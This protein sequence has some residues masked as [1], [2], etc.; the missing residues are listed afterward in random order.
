MG[1][2]L[3]AGEDRH[4]VRSE[5]VADHKA[6]AAK[7]PDIPRCA[8]LGRGGRERVIGRIAVLFPCQSLDQPIDLGHLEADHTDVEVELARSQRLELFGK[9]VS[10]QPAFN[11]SLL[12]AMT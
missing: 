10:S 1:L 9:E 4:R 11:A 5:A 7:V 8:A 6:V 3:P 2:K 12:S